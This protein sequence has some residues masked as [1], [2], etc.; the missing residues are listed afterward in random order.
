MCVRSPV[1]SCGLRTSTSLP[2]ARTC[3]STW[4]RNARCV[5]SSRSGAVYEVAAYD[6]FS[7]VSVRFSCSHLRRP[8]S[9][10]F[11]F[12]CPNNWNTQNA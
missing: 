7:R 4:S 6:G 5:T 2:P 9:M 8:P 3:A 11:A 1:N 10:T 12:V